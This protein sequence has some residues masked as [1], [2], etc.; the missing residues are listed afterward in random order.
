MPLSQDSRSPRSQE[1]LRLCFQ[2]AAGDALVFSRFG[3]KDEPKDQCAELRIMAIAGGALYYTPS[4][5][6]P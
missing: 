1:V 3:K 4:E 5:Q 6:T 2:W